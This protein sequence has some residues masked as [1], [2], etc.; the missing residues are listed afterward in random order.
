MP[1]IKDEE[2]AALKAQADK[3][4]ALEA[5]LAEL[6]KPKDDPK[7]KEDPSLVEK[8]AKERERADAEASK[9]KRLESAIKFDLNSEKFLKDHANLL[10]SEVKD[11]FTQAG[12]ENYADAIE[13]DAA[14]KSGMIQSF[15]S[16][17]ANV[18]LLTAG[19]K[20]QLDDYL[21]LTKTGKQEKAQSVY[22]MI[23]EP[24]FEMLKRVKKAEALQK[25]HGS[26][27]DD[28]Y[29]KRLIAGSRKHYLGETKN[30]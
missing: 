27:D 22:E 25:G 20:S 17:Q 15:F 7:D 3:A 10:P 21:K 8:A 12:K 28:D 4:K 13:K 6:K 9:S 1:E 5:E 11:L 18:D 23:F 29:K 24:A 16:V 14:I 30:A 2:L 19:Q 26:G